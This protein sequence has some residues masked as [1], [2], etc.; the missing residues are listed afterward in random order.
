MTSSDALDAGRAAFADRRWAEA[1][2]RLGLADAAG[3]LGPEDLELLA[4][5]ALL[6]G[7]GRAALA[8]LMRA[9]GAYVVQGDVEGGV[10]TAAWIAVYQIEL[11]EWSHNLEWIP[12]ARRL[13]GSLTEPSSVTGLAMVP[14][15]ILGIASGD[16]RG[17]ER[18][19]AEI[20]EIAERFEDRD[21]AAMS[22]FLRGYC[23]LEL[24]DD[25]AGVARMDDAVTAVA[26]GA[27]SPVFS[28][29]ILCSGVGMAHIGFDLRRVVSW[30]SALDEWC[31]DQPELVAYDGQ[32][33]ALRGALLRL[34]GAWAEAAT[35]AELG[36]ARFRAGDLRAMWGAPYWWGELQRLRGAQHSAAES[37]RRAGESAWDPHPGAAML[38]LAEG[39][40]DRAREA[41]RR[42]AAD[43]D[44]YMRRHRLPA[45]IE[46][47]VAAGDIEAARRAL[48]ELRK[49]AGSAPSPMFA[50]VI[51]FAAAQVRLAEGD[52]AG[53]LAAAREAGDGWRELG[54]P[55]EAARSRVLAGRALRALG[56]GDRARI[57]FHAARGVFLRLGAAPALAELDQIT[58]AGRAGGALTER[59]LEVLRLVSTGLTN[60]LIGERL[61][62]SEK[63]VARHLSNIFA[64]LGLSTRA[65]ATAYAYENGLV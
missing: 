50:A 25:E 18:Q 58:G 64:K 12:R 47:E 65:A 8:L 32:R 17:A 60:R 26:R 53:A 38:L 41:I 11:A 13:A 31:R 46:I 61:S 30:T 9:H 20:E 62:L 28:G 24:G 21:L 59:E 7:E 23:L 63:T 49:R 14:T 6:R 54:I 52:A 44:P 37:F 39:K 36:M 3:A 19:A 34:Q 45:M 10:R 27:V 40:V 16:H 4:T 35:E 55:Y 57:E 33:H 1:Y 48:E 29:F 42:S 22:A 43:A 51:A 56:E 2:E 15:T 5:A